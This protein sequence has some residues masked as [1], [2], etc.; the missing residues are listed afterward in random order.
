MLSTFDD[1]MAQVKLTRTALGK[2]EVTIAFR[3]NCKNNPI[4]SLLILVNLY[5]INT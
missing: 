5:L 3:D 1:V 2:S 4:F